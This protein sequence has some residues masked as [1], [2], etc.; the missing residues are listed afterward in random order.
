MTK[1]EKLKIY[2]SVAKQINDKL[3]Y[4][5]V[6]ILETPNHGEYCDTISLY[7]KDDLYDIWREMRDKSTIDMMDSTFSV[8]KK[9]YYIEPYNTMLLNLAVL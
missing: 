6:E 7:V 8:G 4:E 5:G 3:G 9:R 2:T 1:S